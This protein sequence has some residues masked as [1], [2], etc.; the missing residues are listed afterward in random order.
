MIGRVRLALFFAR[1]DGHRWITQMTMPIQSVRLQPHPLE[2]GT[3][4]AVFP[5]ARTQ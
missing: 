4:P 2:P 1:V 5:S 3:M